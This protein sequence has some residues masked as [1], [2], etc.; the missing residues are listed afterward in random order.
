M[1]QVRPLIDGWVGFGDGASV[2]LESGTPI[3][4]DHP[5]VLERPELFEAIVPAVAPPPPAKKA[6]AKKAA[7]DG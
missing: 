1:S 5:V 4:A 6:A 2:L 7:A 3:D